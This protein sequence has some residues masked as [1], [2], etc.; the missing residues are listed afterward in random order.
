MF[1]LFVNLRVKNSAFSELDMSPLTRYLQGII[2]TIYHLP[3]LPPSFLDAHFV[4]YGSLCTSNIQSV[5]LKRTSMIKIQSRTEM[6][7]ILFCD[8]CLLSSFV[9]ALID[10]SPLFKFVTSLI[11]LKS[12]EKEQK[13]SNNM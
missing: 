5:I 8:I 6:E 4:K 12:Q 2:Q 11:V 3:T 13:D 9:V 10:I 7:Y 1:S